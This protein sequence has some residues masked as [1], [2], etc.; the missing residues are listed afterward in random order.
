MAASA[1]GDVYPLRIRCDRTLGVRSASFVR[2]RL[3]YWI[4]G[5]V[6]VTPAALPAQTTYPAFSVGN[7]HPTVS[8]L[9]SV[10]SP[11]TLASGESVVVDAGTYVSD[12]AAS[13]A[14]LSVT[15]GSWTTHSLYVGYSTGAGALTL[16][17][18]GSSLAVTSSFY[19]GYQKIGSLS[20]TGGADAMGSSLYLGFTS[21]ANGTL[22]VSGAGSTLTLSGSLT[23]G[24]SGTGTFTLSDGA[25][26]TMAGAT[27]GHAAG[28]HGSMAITGSTI[29]FGSSSSVFVGGSGVGEL[30]LQ[31]GGAATAGF[32]YVGY[33][34]GSSGTLTL[35][36]A[37]TTFVNS[38]Y[39][40]IGYN[41]TGTLRVENGASAV[42][43]G[44]GYLY[45]GYNN[46]SQGT[47]TVTGAGSSLSSSQYLYVGYGGTGTLNVEDGGS[48]T[49]Q[50]LALS[51]NGGSG[52]VNLSGT[53]STL[54]VTHPFGWAF[55]DHGAA[56]VNITSG[57]QLDASAGGTG[58]NGSGTLNVS[59]GGSVLGRIGLSGG[60]LN[61]GAGS[62]LTDGID[63]YRG[64]ATDSTLNILSGGS[65]SG[66]FGFYSI[67]GAT[68]YN[69]INVAA[70]GSITSAL[71]LQDTILT[72]G[73]TFA[74]LTV[75]G[76]SQVRPGDG[77]GS[78]RIDGALTLKPG[79]V[80]T[81]DFRDAAGVAGTGWDTLSVG[82]ALTVNGYDGDRVVVGI[83][84]VGANGLAGLASGFD[85]A[86]NY[87]WPLF[88]DAASLA[89]ATGSTLG[90]AFTLDMSEF[91][92]AFGGTFALGQS[93]NTLAL[94]YTASA[95]PE[96]ST[97]AAIAGALGLLAAALR[98]QRR[99]RIPLA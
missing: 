4:I 21:P 25:Q 95:I 11:Y 87:S 66:P 88:T 92:N 83:R 61:V 32:T 52:T 20:L 45:V 79:S 26:A 34:A 74:S 41:G 33:A 29:D 91:A 31:A 39:F 19:V 71:S 57:A 38:G 80:F 78:L 28:A 82:G 94:T 58:V 13:G 59:G 49:T 36:G 40:Y 81:F 22:S 89:F 46:G 69:R 24:Y 35:S 54:N 12:T 18:S 68:N 63:F 62:T 3:G 5:V 8:G 37:E 42:E 44:Y 64:E 75:D 55:G 76:G 53:G 98:R 93:G 6:L 86:Q 43:N 96:P 85:P 97:Y 73:G 65:V 27:I 56:T 67:V 1:S 10:A 15:S 51:R 70:G 72:G 90:T 77:V 23:A 50:T 14:S 99:A 9:T 16:S 2:C 48:V 60:T 17:G 84:T 7:D 47:A 30:T